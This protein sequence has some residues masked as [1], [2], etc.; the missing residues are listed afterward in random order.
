MSPL[1][2]LICTMVFL[3]LACGLILVKGQVFK[4]QG[5]D[6]INVRL[7]TI[8]SQL[9]TLQQAA[10]KPSEAIDLT[11]INQDFN[12]LVGLIEQLKSKE[13]ISSKDNH[14]EVIEKLDVLLDMVKGLDKKQHPV[15]YLPVTALP[16]KVISI[17]S[18]QQVS[19]ATVSYNFKTLP[20]EKSDS[21]AGWS[22]L[23]LDFGKQKIE[24]ENG[25]KERVAI[26]MEEGSHA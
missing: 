11:I 2:Y 4:T 24:L 1:K 12:K 7:T 22:I 8:Q 10:K 3:V 15:K 5:S 16:F 9:N 20:L 14:P 18:I 21:L 26:N 6:E 19:V 13:E 25:N 23:N 17:D